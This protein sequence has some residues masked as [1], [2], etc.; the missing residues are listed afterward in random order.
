MFVFVD[1]N[2]SIVTIDKLQ[3]VRRETALELSSKGAI[4]TVFG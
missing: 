4:L 2:I 3:P 1:T